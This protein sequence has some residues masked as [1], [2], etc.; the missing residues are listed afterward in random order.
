MHPVKEPGL[1]AHHD[2]AHCRTSAMRRNN[3]LQR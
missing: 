2:T 1:L 3:N